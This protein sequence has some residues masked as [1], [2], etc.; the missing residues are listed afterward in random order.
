M[1]A[2]RKT[3]GKAIKQEPQ[4]GIPEDITDADF[5]P[6]D[7][8]IE[9]INDTLDLKKYDEFYEPAKKTS[10]K[11]RRAPSMNAKAIKAREKALGEKF[12]EVT[13]KLDNVLEK[14]DG[15]VVDC[16]YHAPTKL[17]TVSISC[18]VRLIRYGN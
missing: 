3:R 16:F 5:V 2:P 17:A 7:V 18:Y 15:I 4:A 14:D 10:R 11:G 8:A 6:E 12:V 1:L 9:S 13:S